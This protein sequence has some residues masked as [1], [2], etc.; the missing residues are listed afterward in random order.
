MRAGGSSR[1]S[2]CFETTNVCID[3][4]YLNEDIQGRYGEGGCIYHVHYAVDPETFSDTR[5]F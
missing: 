2:T 3:D 4:A 1:V 5:P